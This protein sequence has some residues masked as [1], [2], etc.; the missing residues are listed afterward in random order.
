MGSVAEAI[1]ELQDYDFNTS[2][3]ATYSN[4]LQ[5]KDNY[6]NNNLVWIPSSVAA[7]DTYA[8]SER[9]AGNVGIAPAGQTR[10]KLKGISSTDG[11]PNGYQ[12]GLNYVGVMF[13]HDSDDL[14]DLNENYFNPIYFVDEDNLQVENAQT[15]YKTKSD[16]Q[17]IQIRRHILWVKE[18]L[19]AI[20]G[21]VRFDSNLSTTWLRFYGPADDFLSGEK[22][23]TVLED[24]KIKLDKTTTTE[25]MKD[26]NIMKAKIWL[27]YA[28]MIKWVWVD[29][30]ITNNIPA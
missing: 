12:A 14:D 2:W 16:L 13:D 25:D 19:Q 4:V 15:L 29:L 3:L 11:N 28:N 7:I 5:I 1:A 20:S 27:K 30:I 24:Y 21:G 8:L 17:E 6:N 18:K 22:S 10:G 9:I 23:A 26:Q